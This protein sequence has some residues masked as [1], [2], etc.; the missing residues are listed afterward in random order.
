MAASVK[1]HFKTDEAIQDFTLEL[2]DTPATQ[3]RGLMFR[4]SLPERG[5]MLFAFP[6]TAPRQFWMK[7]TF[8]SLDMLFL[9]SARQVVGVV[10]AA[11]PQTLTLRSVP[12]PARYVIELR[13]GTAARARIAVGTQVDFVLPTRPL[14]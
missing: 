4:D 2:A 8:V 3:A 9:N 10:A 7:N 11:E 12:A 14:R 13:G 6:E 5:G 1:V